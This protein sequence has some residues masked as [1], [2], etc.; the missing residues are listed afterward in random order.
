[1]PDSTYL[2]AIKKITPQYQEVRGASGKLLFMIDPA[3]GL[4]QIKREGKIETI[5]IGMIIASSQ[6]PSS[7]L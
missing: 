6:S 2:K 5:D 1:M 3:R 7:V 4:I